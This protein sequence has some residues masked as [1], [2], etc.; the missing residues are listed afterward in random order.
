MNLEAIKRG[1][2]NSKV[3]LWPGSTVEVVVRILSKQEAQEAFFAAE[4]RFQREKVQ[5]Q[6]HN[7]EEF[8]EE[9]A[10]QQ[11]FRAVRDVDGGAPLATSVE[12][13][14]SLISRDDVDRLTE[15]YSAFEDEVGGNLESATEEEVEILL[16]E[17]KKSQRQFLGAFQ[18]SER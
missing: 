11:L 13:F 7:L 2:K 16:S 4:Q 1:I 12:V 6:L 9:R 3:V 8:Q 14:R 15:I 10:I 17:L 18:I 5:V